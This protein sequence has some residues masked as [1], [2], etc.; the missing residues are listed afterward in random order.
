MGTDDNSGH[1]WIINLNNKEIGNI[2]NPEEFN[3]VER[4]AVHGSDFE[5]KKE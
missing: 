1:N 4:L 2:Y 5:L 3:S